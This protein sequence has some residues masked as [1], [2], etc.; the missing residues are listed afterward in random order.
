MS[1]EWGNLKK[2]CWVVA[3]EVYLCFKRYV[4]IWVWILSYKQGSC[5]YFL[6]LSVQVRKHVNDLYEDLRDGH[7]L[8]SLLEVLS[9]DT[10]VSFLIIIQW[11]QI[12]NYAFSL[13]TPCILTA[14]DF[15]DIFCNLWLN[16]KD[17]SCISLGKYA[18]VNSVGECNLFS[19]FLVASETSFLNRVMHYF[20]CSFLS[21][22][23]FSDFCFN[24]YWMLNIF[25]HLRE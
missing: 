3:S 12:V 20:F 13:L 18:G 14:V 10:L 24:K 7:N 21:F 22:P 2:Q 1:W 5:I 19:L 15:F 16:T 9:G 17:T 6:H 25:L 8:I 11:F 4:L 23:L